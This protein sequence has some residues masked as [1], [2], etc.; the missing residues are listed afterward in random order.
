MLRFTLEK[1]SYGLLCVS[2]D[3]FWCAILFLRS[4]WWGDDRPVGH[5]RVWGVIL[6]CYAVF[7]KT[8][9]SVIMKVVV[10]NDRNRLQAFAKTIVWKRQRATVFLWSTYLDHMESEA[11]KSYIERADTMMKTA[12]NTHNTAMCPLYRAISF[13]SQQCQNSANIHLLNHLATL[14]EPPSPVDSR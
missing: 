9:R 2:A 13:S 4:S 12:M 11:W 10:V 3:A 14:I 8:M 1:A 5:W 6:G 7:P